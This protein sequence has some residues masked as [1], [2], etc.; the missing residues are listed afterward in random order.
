VSETEL[1][2]PVVDA[3]ESS[4]HRTEVRDLV[5][6]VQAIRI[7]QSVGGKLADLL[8]TLADFMRARQEIRREVEVLT[9]EG[10]MSAKVLAVLPIFLFVLL[11]A[12]NPGYL[13]PMLHGWHLA[14]LLGAAGWM[15]VGVIVMFRT[16]RLEV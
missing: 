8:Q 12:I 1:G 2:K 11:Q 7:Q 9:A 14:V 3:L 6:V 16:L 4:A 15:V 5:W 13:D 10:R